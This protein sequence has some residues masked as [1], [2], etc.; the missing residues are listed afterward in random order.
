[1]SSRLHRWREALRAWSTAVLLSVRQRPDRSLQFC[2]RTSATP[3]GATYQRRRAAMKSFELEL[4]HAEVFL[5][6]ENCD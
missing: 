3:E 5:A 2:L 4:N 6:Y 1:V